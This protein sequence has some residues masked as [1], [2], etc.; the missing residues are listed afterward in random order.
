M[1]TATHFVMGIGLAGLAYTDPAVA[2]D[3]K[4]AA[5]ILIATVVG[6]Q[7]PDFDT[8]FRLENNAAYI[9]NHRG[10]SHSIPF[11]LIWILSITGL[12]SL[13]FSDVSTGHVALWVTIAVCLHVFTDLFNTYGTQAFRPFTQKWISWN[14]IHIFDPFIFSTHIAAIMLWITRLIPPAPL[15]ITLYAAIGLYYVW[16]TWSHFRLKKRVRDMDNERQKGDTYYIIPTVSWNRWHVVKAHQN[17]SYDIGG[18]HGKRLFWKKHAVPST[19][20]AAEA[21]KS[22]R[23]VQAFRY[24]SS[25]AVAEVEEREWG[26]IVRWADV[27]YRHR[28]QYPF[29]AVAVM[30]KQ[31]GLIDSYIGW[32]SHEKME[33]RLF[34]HMN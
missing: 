26:Y 3:P 7:A 9:R 17:G 31:F 32:L 14:I 30:N 12:I 16:R 23:D 18:L 5:V 25:F 33:K 4:L 11:W 6:S 21:S 28:R 34:P 2:E 27:R 13:I 24:F 15:F 8:L 22:Y 10:M 19:H 1:D 20:P 29:V